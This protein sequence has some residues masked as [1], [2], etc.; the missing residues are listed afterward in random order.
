[1]SSK[2]L[3]TFRYTT[4]QLIVAKT[5]GSK[6]VSPLDIQSELVVLEKIMRTLKEL[7]K[8]RQKYGKL[9]PMVQPCSISYVDLLHR[10]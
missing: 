2:P 8:L 9:S 1:M 7:G 5:E 10:P 4:I 3:T 6:G